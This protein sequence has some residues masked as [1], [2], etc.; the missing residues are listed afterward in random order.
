MSTDI[1]DFPPVERP[2]VAVRRF[3]LING[4]FIF[5]DLLEYLGLN[6]EE[7]R[8]EYGEKLIG[9]PACLNKVISEMVTGR[10]RESRKRRSVEHV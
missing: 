6:E 10:I 3:K 1:F 8:K 5:N 9:N 7:F 2:Y 4:G